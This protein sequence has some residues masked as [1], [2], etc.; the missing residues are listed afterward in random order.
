MGYNRAYIKMNNKILILILMAIG[1]TTALSSCKKDEEP[2]N[3]TKIV[4]PEGALP[5]LFSVSPTKKVFFAN[6]NLQYQAS[7]NTW[8]FAANQWDTIGCGNILRSATY[9]GWIDL[10]SYGTSG[11]NGAVPYKFYGQY[12]D[13]PTNDISGT[14]YDWGGY[15]PISNAGNKAGLWR[16]LT[17]D[18]IRYM[19]Y[20]RSFIGYSFGLGKLKLQND[21]EMIG[22]FIF[23]DDSENYSDNYSSNVIKMSV[24]ELEATGTVF[25]PYTGVIN[26]M[27][28]GSYFY[29]KDHLS[30]YLLGSP[31]CLEF[32]TGY[33]WPPTQSREYGCVRLVC[34]YK[35]Q[36]NK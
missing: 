3:E 17:Y 27:W 5:H 19:L 30:V 28:S 18:E 1:F 25:L 11:Y 26:Q 15:N 31:K 24:S 33:L 23:P 14:N 8:R 13:L 9:E 36:N 6:G 16:S 4:V 12:E 10:F 21:S 20:Q 35:E 29:D 22:V 34:D 32:V 7:T 2:D